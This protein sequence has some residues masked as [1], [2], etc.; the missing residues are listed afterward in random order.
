M[1]KYICI[2]LLIYLFRC[3]LIYM[4]IGLLTLCMYLP[5]YLFMNYTF[6]YLSMYSCMYVCMHARMRAR[7]YVCI[8]LCMY[9]GTYVRTYVC[10]YVCNLGIFKVLLKLFSLNIRKSF[11]EALRGVLTFVAESCT[12]NCL[13]QLNL[14]L[15]LQLILVHN[16][17]PNISQNVCLQDC[18]PRLLCHQRCMFLVS[19]Q[20]N[21]D[22]C[23][24][25]V[26]AW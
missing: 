24:Q 5:F 2:Y 23:D 10:M 16:I 14:G 13:R 20:W 22:L 25:H 15:R 3:S 26:Q 9:V 18:L 1:F 21:Q 12:A 19:V 6:L 11:T 7:M 8:Y 17:C 4:F